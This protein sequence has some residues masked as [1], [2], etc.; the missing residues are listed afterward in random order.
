MDIV[1]ESIKNP[2]TS[3]WVV[4]T[5]TDFERLT[6]NLRAVN[7]Q[8]IVAKLQ[9]RLSFDGADMS[10]SSRYVIMFMPRLWRNCTTGLVSLVNTYGAVQSP[11]GSTLNQKWSPYVFLNARREWKSLVT[12]I[13]GY[14]S[15]K[16]IFTMCMSFRSTEGSMC[17]PSILKWGGFMY[18]FSPRNLLLVSTLLHFWVQQRV[19]WPVPHCHPELVLQ[20]LLIPSWKFLLPELFSRI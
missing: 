16:S 5:S 1:L 13:I 10:V 2:R 12:G 11:N 18:Q 19:D 14:T 6:I 17:K 8:R 20:L 15:F 3:N 9:S 7:S 4:G